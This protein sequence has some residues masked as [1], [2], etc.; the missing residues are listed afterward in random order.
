MG[1]KRVKSARQAEKPDAYNRIIEQIFFR[2]YREKASSVEFTREEIPTAARELK[3]PVP[4]NLGDVIYS[5][6]YRRP[7]PSSILKTCRSGEE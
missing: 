3:V 6:R 7:L 4:D 1:T 2:H 5:F